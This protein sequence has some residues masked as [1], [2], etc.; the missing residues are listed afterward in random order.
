MKDGSILSSISED[1]KENCIGIVFWS[2]DPTAT[3]PVLKA[4]H[5]NC[6][7]GLVVSLHAEIYGTVWQTNYEFT[8]IQSWAEVQDFYIS[9]G[10][11]PLGYKYDTPGEIQGYNNTKILEA[12][13]RSHSSFPVTILGCFN[14]II[15]EEI[16]PV[17]G[18]TSE[19]Y[20]PS[21]KELLELYNVKSKVDT[22]L[23]VS[24]GDVLGTSN[25]W[26]SGEKNDNGYYAFY[27][28]MYRGDMNQMTKVSRHRVCL[29][30]AF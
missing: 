23:S 13:N 14:E 20:L 8:T 16:F 28:S 3:D 29:V 21:P 9:G 1:N 26:S 15:G 4:G 27:V 7:H 12:Y 17:E 25:Y 10:Y 6:T 24:G 18:K 11:K 5:S 19:W 2:G 30:F 22:S